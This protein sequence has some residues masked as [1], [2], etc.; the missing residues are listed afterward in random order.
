M[1]KIV[2]YVVL[3]LLIENL[4]TYDDLVSIGIKEENWES[5]MASRKKIVDAICT[6]IVQWNEKL[7][8][9]K[10]YARGV[11]DAKVEL[12]HFGP[13]F[14]VY[15]PILN[16]D[17]IK[18]IYTIA[19]LCLPRVLLKLGTTG[20]FVRGALTKGYGW[21]IE[22]GN[23]QTLYGPVMHR[24]WKITNDWDYSP[25]VIIDHDVFEVVSDPSNYGAGEDGQWLLLYARR[26]YDG[27]GILDYL[28]HDTGSRSVM[29]DSEEVV[30]E[31]MKTMLTIIRSLIEAL[32]RKSVEHDNST[33]IR[34]ALVLEDYL[35][36]SI[37][38]WTGEHV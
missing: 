37:F 22:E 16:L 21:K 36:T 15:L 10:Y 13:V 7:L 8:D 31:E 30:I 6:M 18:V 9:E 35:R 2:E 3:Y 11:G 32:A 14:L 23:C 20:R 12:Q 17:S 38:S 1:Y 34:K 28:A 25:R 26:D 24:A 4:G 19:A 27:Q 5:E 29:I 33:S